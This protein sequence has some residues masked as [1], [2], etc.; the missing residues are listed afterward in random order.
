[1]PNFNVQL[2][3]YGHTTD[4][5]KQLLYLTYFEIDRFAVKTVTAVLLYQKLIIYFIYPR[6]EP[7]F[8]I[9]SAGD[10]KLINYQCIRLIMNLLS[11]T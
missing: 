1:M 5:H 4:K 8:G 7:V 3:F 9:V 10:Q 6:G 11:V 2:R